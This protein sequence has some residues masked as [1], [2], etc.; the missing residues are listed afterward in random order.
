VN[1][2]VDR[3]VI[4]QGDVPLRDHSL[5]EFAQT[6]PQIQEPDGSPTWLARGANFV[7]A[8]TRVR[9]GTVLAR[10][11]Q[12]DEYMVV[13]PPELSL[14]IA[15]GADALE[16]EADSLTIVPPG[17]SAVT[18]KGEGYVYRFFSAGAGDL[19]NLSVNAAVYADGAPEVAPL[20]PWPDPVGGFRL[21]TYP[22]GK[23]SSG[24]AFGRI[25]RSTNLMVNLF[26]PFNEARRRDALSPHH[27]DDFEQGSL[28]LAGDFEHYL[29]A[30]W[31]KDRAAWKPDETV[32][33]GSPSLTVIPARTIHTTAWFGPGRMIDIF[34]PPRMDFSA[35]PGWVRNAADYPMPAAEGQAE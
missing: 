33:C 18:A 5:A 9:A 14:H 23:L 27:H 35:K 6:K 2:F 25:F 28:C 12:P 26:E 22:L 31:G 7:V 10:T 29:R 17:D 15:A 16:A 20:E 8:V 30:P 3:R 21:R 1:T 32:R 34:A 24:Q 13:A 4:L 11:G 19:A